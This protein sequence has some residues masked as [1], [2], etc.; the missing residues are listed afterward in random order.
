VRDLQGRPTCSAN[1]RDKWRD[2]T[3]SRAASASTLFRSRAPSSIRT[4]ALGGCGTGVETH[5]A[6]GWCACRAYGSAVYPGCLDG[7]EHHSVE[8]WTATSKRLMNVASRSVPSASGMAS[9][10]AGLNPLWGHASW[11]GFRWSPVQIARSSRL[12]VCYADFPIHLSRTL[13]LR[14]ASAGITIDQTPVIAAWELASRFG[15]P[16]QLVPAGSLALCHQAA[17]PGENHEHWKK[18]TSSI[19]GSNSPWTCL[20]SHGRR[21]AREPLGRQRCLA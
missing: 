18:R 17:A 11:L 12:V 7:N 8:G 6:C 14:S 13:P 4:S 2:P 16:Q 15:L 5:I 3:P 21:C 1:R 19:R 9:R 10:H 20:G